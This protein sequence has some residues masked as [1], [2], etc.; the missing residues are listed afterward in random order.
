MG[1]QQ[2]LKVIELDHYRMMATKRTTTICTEITSLN[3]KL[4]DLPGSTI[5]KL[6]ENNYDLL[7][8]EEWE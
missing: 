7:T 5:S 6:R 3:K 8:S 2:S 4:C 1:I